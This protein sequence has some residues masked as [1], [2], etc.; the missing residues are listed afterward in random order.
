MQEKEAEKGNKIWTVNLA[1][2]LPS[3]GGIRIYITLDKQDLAIQFWTEE[4]SSQKLFQQ[5]FYLLNE[6]LQES[7]FT[8]SQLKAF[9][10]IP[11][12][13]QHEQKASQFIIDERV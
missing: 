10:G 13:A 12:S 2:H 11:E 4:K 5:F 1:F 8:I 7:G 3:L 9:H 6:R